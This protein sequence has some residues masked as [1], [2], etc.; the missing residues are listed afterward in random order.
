MLD[1]E[2]DLRKAIALSEEE[3]AKRKKALEDANAKALFDDSQQTYVRQSFG[4]FW[5][6]SP[7]SVG[8]DLFAQQPMQQMNTG[9]PMQQM[10]PQYTSFNVSDQS[11]QWWSVAEEPYLAIHATANDATA[12]TATAGRIHASADDAARAGEAEAGMVAGTR[13][14]SERFKAC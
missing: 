7:F 5:G 13:G 10:Q 6:L 11:S 4:D 3:E 1:R 14:L 9:W 2:E 8:S 12:A